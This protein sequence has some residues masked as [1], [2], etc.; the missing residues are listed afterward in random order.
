MDKEILKLLK[1]HE[2]LTGEQPWTGYFTF[3]LGGTFET[4]EALH[5]KVLKT[6]NKLE[7]QGKVEKVKKASNKTFWKS[8]A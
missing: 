8:K 3:K 7:K 2:K 5:S 1:A 4:W 6:L